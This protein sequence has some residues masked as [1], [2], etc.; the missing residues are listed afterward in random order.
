MISIDS[1]YYYYYYYYYL[2]VIIARSPVFS[3]VST[4]ITGLT[5]VRAFGAQQLFEKQFDRYQNDNS[6]AFFMFTCTVQRIR[7]FNGFGFA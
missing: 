1:H 5:T 3:H 4:T 7:Y 6:A 2:I